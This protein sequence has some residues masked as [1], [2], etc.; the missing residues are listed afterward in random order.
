ME[1]NNLFQTWN[2]QSLDKSEFSE[3]LKILVPKNKKVNFEWGC[4]HR[5]LKPSLFEKIIESLNIMNVFKV[6]Y[7]HSQF[8]TFENLKNFEKNEFE[9]LINKLARIK[10]IKYILSV[11]KEKDKNSIFRKRVVFSEAEIK[12]VFIENKKLMGNNQE[13]IL[14]IV[15]AFENK[16]FLR[17]FEL[18]N[19]K[20]K[21][22]QL[23]IESDL[24]N[25][26]KIFVIFCSSNLSD[27]LILR[28]IFG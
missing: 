1:F 22:I 21:R 20:Y 23:H 9:L 26:D 5:I 14:E 4:V 13:N 2:F 16:D 18:F 19:K 12:K 11:K 24:N 15:K 25:E 3:I 27:S 10:E 28:K 6:D 8:K 17:I 7:P